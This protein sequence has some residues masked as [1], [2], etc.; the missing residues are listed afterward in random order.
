[1]VLDNDVIIVFKN[2]APQGHVVPLAV[3]FP[4]VSPLPLPPTTLLHRLWTPPNWA[5]DALSQFIKPFALL[6]G[7]AGLP[8]NL[9]VVAPPNLAASK[10]QILL[11]Y[12]NKYN[13]QSEYQDKLDKM[14]GEMKKLQAAQ[15]EH[16]KLLKNQ[17]RF[18]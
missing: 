2:Q 10:L 13:F 14:T 3:L 16:A 17:V 9:L 1:M 11:Q 18:S 4:P 12:I 8:C 6:P 5:L 7:S 15:K